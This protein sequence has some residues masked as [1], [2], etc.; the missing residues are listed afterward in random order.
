MA[1]KF[2]GFL[3]NVGRGVTNPKG[4]VG[5]FRH[6]ARL[7]VDNLFRLAPKQKFLFFV[8]FNI[9]P[10]ALALY[11]QLKNRHQN[12]LN[13]LCKT[14]DLPQYSANL[15]V[16]NQYNRKKVVQTAIDYTPISITLHD[17]NQ[18]ITTFMLEAYYKYY[19]RD[20]RVENPA[21]AYM[22]RNTYAAERKDRY[23]L[24]NG[25][26]KPFFNNIKLF[27]LSRQQFTEYTLINPLIERWGHDTMDYSDGT[28]PA[29]NSMIINYE[30]VM[31]DRGAVKDDLPATFGTSHYDTSP[32]PLNIQGGGVANVFG[33]G[34]VIDGATSV[35]GDFTDG[36][37]G[38]G[39][40]LSTANTIKN[41]TKLT[42]SGVISE[43]KS[44]FNSAV[45]NLGNSGTNGVT[46]PGIAFTGAA[47]S[48]QLSDNGGG[49]GLP[50]TTIPGSNR[51]G[52]GE[53]TTALA[54][55]PGANPRAGQNTA[56]AARSTPGA[57]PRGTPGRLGTSTRPGQ[58]PTPTPT[59]TGYP[60]GVGPSS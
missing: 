46:G 60:P 30:A 17:D 56:S 34:G 31:Y 21:R 27:Q 8:N 37:F 44:N 24:D 32:S 35:V 41:A 26:V 48:G 23:G 12:E 42:K 20:S 19:Y 50:G 39:S 53:V 5:D 47:G 10:E 33:G 49:T 45:V 6:A 54:D 11:P 36:S 22:P 38:L 2:T 57:N 55:T 59:G 4:N 51:P 9:D 29:E 43:L 28:S 15:E 40:I 1:N 25:T 3:D 7:Y 16:K 13:M 52:Q 14:A 18:G 58:T